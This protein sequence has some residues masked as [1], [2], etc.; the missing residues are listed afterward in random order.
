MQLIDHLETYSRG[1]YGG[2]IGFISP[3]GDM[4]MAIMIR[5]FSSRDN[6][7]YF[8]AGAGVVASSVPERELQEVT[9][10]LK[11]LH[12]AIELAKEI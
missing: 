5:S 3:D 1:Y 12:L 10:K 9:E 11:G 4:N 2:C 6:T 7:L 8:R